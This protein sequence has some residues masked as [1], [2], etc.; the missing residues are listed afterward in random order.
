MTTWTLKANDVDNNIPVHPLGIMARVLLVG[1]FGP[2]QRDDEYGS[3]SD[4]PM[5]LFHN[6]VTREE[7]AWDVRMFVRH[8]GMYLMYANIEAPC[9]V[10][11]YPTL[12][13]FEQELRNV[14][15][16]IIGISGIMVNILKV[17]KMCDL[18]RRYQPRAEIVVGGHIARLPD[19]AKRIS[20]DHIVIGDGVAWFRKHLNQNLE[21]PLRHPML[22]SSFGTRT[23]GVDVGDPPNDT[24]A[25]VI[26][27]AGCRMGCN[28]CNTSAHFGGK[29]EVINFFKTGDELF[30]IMD[31]LE[32]HLGSRSFFIMD[33]NFLVNRKRALR[34]LELMEQTGK[35]WSLYIFASAKLIQSYKIEQLVRL[36]ISWVWLGLEG[37]GANY[38][39]LNGTDTHELVRFLQS[40][41]IRVLGST[42]IGLPE[43]SPENIDRVI[44]YAVSHAT[45]FHQFMLY[46]PLPGTTLYDACREEKL[47]LGEDECPL[48]DMHGQRRFNW[49]HPHLLPGTETAIL[50]RA[51]R[52]DYAV[53]GPSLLRCVRTTLHGYKRYKDHPNLAIRDRYRWEAKTLW[54]RDAG[55]AWAGCHYFTQKG[56]PI[57]VRKLERLLTDLHAEFGMKSRVAAP[58]IGRY[59]TYTIVK[60]EGRLR[61]GWTYEPSTRYVFNRKEARYRQDTRRVWQ[62]GE[63]LDVLMHQVP[64]LELPVR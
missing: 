14:H 62:Y 21:A 30:S 24:A 20:A 16:D 41:G 33:E 44:D 40:H 55:M 5:E 43:H 47:L 64:L 6:Q 53:N 49:R 29:G 12:E 56:N 9:T 19:L 2:Y 26:P 8:P 35:A 57:V 51:F 61:K 34:L 46:T 32:T 22:V 45:D 63:V 58:L 54:K 52:R 31:Q 15:Y 39:K 18:I 27:S 3:R 60:E 37:E 28:F 42:I 48:P 25:M 38:S 1:V 13:R 23:L 7:G 11:E 17:K 36:G 50:Q 4:N 10:L 59:L